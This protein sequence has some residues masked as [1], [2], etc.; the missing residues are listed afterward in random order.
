M[1]EESAEEGHRYVAEGAFSIGLGLM[2]IIAM[3][4]AMLGYYE[5][6][7]VLWIGLLASGMLTISGLHVNAMGWYD[8][9]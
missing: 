6:E 9:A 3:A 7:G 4:G 5:P 8:G 1:S 2:G